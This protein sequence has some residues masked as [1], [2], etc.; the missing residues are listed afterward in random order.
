MGLYSCTVATLSFGTIQL[1]CGCQ[2][3]DEGYQ[4]HDEGYQS[5]VTLNEAGT[6]WYPE[7]REPT[8]KRRGS[9][10]VGREVRAFQKEKRKKK[11]LLNFCMP[12]GKTG[13]GRSTHLKEQSAIVL[14]SV[15]GRGFGW[16]SK[17]SPPPP[18]KHT[19]ILPAWC[20]CQDHLLLAPLAP[21]GVQ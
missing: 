17:L 12:S 10:K 9:D 3:H 18:P 6:P 2:P 4:P 16:H 14:L 1:H 20:V 5:H 21:S 19:H 7:H 13:V 8:P 15:P 11:I